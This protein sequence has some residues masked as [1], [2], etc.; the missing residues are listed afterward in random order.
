MGSKRIPI[1]KRSK[2]IFDFE[3]WKKKQPTKQLY[4][5]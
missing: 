2:G 3:E 5:N 4:T 1:E